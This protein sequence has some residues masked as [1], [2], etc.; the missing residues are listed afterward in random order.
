MNI[1]T[2]RKLIKEKEITQND[3]ASQM[4]ISGNAI[5]Q[6]L[7]K[8]DFKV[9]DLEKMAKILEV[10]V[11]YFFEEEKNENGFNHVANVHGNKQHVIVNGD[12]VLLEKIKG[13]ENQVLLLNERIK[14]KEEMIVQLK[15]RKI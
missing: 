4:G 15:E 2:I 13:L 3:I 7:K 5:S 9:S 10:P 6:K 1:N 12:K 8:G 14:D 11:N